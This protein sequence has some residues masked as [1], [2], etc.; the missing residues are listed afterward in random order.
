MLPD[1]V[2]AADK[3]Y[4]GIDTIVYATG[5]KTSQLLHPMT[6]TGGCGWLYSGVIHRSPT[7]SSTHSLTPPPTRSPPGRGGASLHDCWKREGAKALFGIA[8]PR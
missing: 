5:F 4:T 1:G 2:V 3:R 6:I 8:V 7:H